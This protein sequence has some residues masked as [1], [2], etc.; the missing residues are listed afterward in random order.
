MQEDRTSV[1]RT[2]RLNLRKQDLMPD[3]QQLTPPHLELAKPS[4][5]LSYAIVAATLRRGWCT[6]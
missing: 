2:S 1:R 6:N 5:K 3:D 4:Q